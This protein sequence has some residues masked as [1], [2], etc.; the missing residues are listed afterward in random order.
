ME[1]PEEAYC[2]TRKYFGTNHKYTVHPV[3][4][5]YYRD[6]QL[7]T[8]VR[9]TVKDLSRT[10]LTFRVKMNEQTKQDG[11]HYMHVAI[12]EVMGKSSNL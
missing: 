3:R 7:M 5:I 8:F 2:V 12:L 6:E 10:D 4:E 11:N 9:C 1:E